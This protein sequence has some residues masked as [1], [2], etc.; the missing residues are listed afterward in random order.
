MYKPVIAIVGRPNVGKS[1]FFNRVIGSRTAIVDE[2]AGSTRDRI[3][4][5]GDWAGHDFLLIDT[6]GLVADPDEPLAS[7]IAA[8]VRLACDEADVIVFIVDGKAGL[9][10]QDQDIANQLRRV[11]KPILVAVN[12]IDDPKQTVNTHEFYQLGLGEPMA[13]SA[14]RGTGD[15]GDLLDKIVS[16]FPKKSKPNIEEG[17]DGEV[18]EEEKELKAFSIAIVGKPNVGKSSIVNFLCGSQRCIVTPEAGTTRDAIDTTIRYKGK[19]ITLIDT[20][21]IR[22]KSKVSYGVEAF[23]VVRSLS[24]LSRADVVAIVLDANEGV[25][26]QDQKIARKIEEAGKPCVVVLNK[27]D[28]VENR[29]SSSMKEYQEELDRELPHLKFAEVVFSSAQTKQR[30][31]KIM[32]AAER[33]LL[34]GRRRIST[35]LVNQVINE[36]VALVPPPASKRGKRLRIYYSSQVSTSPPTFLLFSNDAKLLTPSYRTYIERKIRE[37]F[38]FAGTP[39][40]VALRSKER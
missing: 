17:E 23:S 11:K 25:S 1:T 5:D 22:R 29:S 18:S 26:D 13:L 6:G 38:G 14:M 7:E 21:G 9:T 32:E 3:Y 19:D 28:L 15:V 34:Q 4:R 20:A 37:A 40:V 8:Q 36:A 12:K 24:A 35:S 33:A 10:G 31:A 2:F 30:V 27:W 16:F 39:I